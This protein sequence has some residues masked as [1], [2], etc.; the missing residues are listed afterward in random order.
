[1]C[2]L[3]NEIKRNIENQ[4]FCWVDLCVSRER[5]FMKL[6]AVKC[7]RNY[8]SARF[9][10]H[11]D[12]CLRLRT[13]I[14]RRIDLFRLE[15]F[16]APFGCCLR[17]KAYVKQFGFVFYF[18]VAVLCALSE[19]KTTS[20]KYRFALSWATELYLFLKCAIRNWDLSLLACMNQ[21]QKYPKTYTF[22]LCANLYSSFRV[23]REIPN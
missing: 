20:I 5:L 10:F 7:V 17:P 15:C 11:L 1:M 21:M 22:L 18:A 23:Q 14:V 4:M 16:V 2:L 13:L 3:D 9:W 8:V 6:D 19:W 12:C